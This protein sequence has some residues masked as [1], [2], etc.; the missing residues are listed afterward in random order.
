MESKANEAEY[1]A[2]A[3]DKLEVAARST[4]ADTAQRLELGEARHAAEKARLTSD[5]DRELETQRYGLADVARHVIL[6]ILEPRFL[7]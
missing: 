3:R 2:A 6:H 5:K 4:A 7:T 1:L